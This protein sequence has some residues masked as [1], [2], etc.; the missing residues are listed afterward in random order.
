M[1]AAD[2]IGAWGDGW[3][4]RLRGVGVQGVAHKDGRHTDFRRIP[5]RRERGADA[6][7]GDVPGGDHAE[8]RRQAA[9]RGGRDD[10]Q[11]DLRGRGPYV[12]ARRGRYREHN[13]LLYDQRLR[14]ACG[15]NHV[16]LDEKGCVLRSDRRQPR[17]YGRHHE[18]P[19]DGEHRREP[20]VL[21]ETPDHPRLQ[22]L[23]TRG[24][25]MAH[26]H[27]HHRAAR[28]DDR[29]RP[30]QLQRMAGRHVRMGDRTM[31]LHAEP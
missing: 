28:N 3:R 2:P 8:E 9:R 24:E 6:V 16:Q 1:G 30:A 25:R 7:R 15:E 20:H 11:G 18:V 29:A 10:R 26:H 21:R 4:D 14:A 31:A 12:Q 27:A 5:R 19:G 13:W 22:A 17:L 23:R